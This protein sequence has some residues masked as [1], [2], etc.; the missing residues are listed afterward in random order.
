[1]ING[2]RERITQKGS[3]ISEEKNMLVSQGPKRVFTF[4]CMYVLMFL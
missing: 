3:R 4:I 1:M 2:E